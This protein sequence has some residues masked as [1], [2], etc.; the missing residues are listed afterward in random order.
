MAWIPI[1]G[2]LSQYQKSD[3]DL[4]SN[5]YIKFYASGTSTA[6]QMATDSSGSTLLDKCQLDSSGYPTTDG[7]SRFIPRIDQKY[8]IVL[9][10]N[11]ADANSNNTANADWIV[12]DV[13]TLA[14]DSQTVKESDFRLDRSYSTLSNAISSVGG[15]E[16]ELHLSE[17]SQNISSQLGISQAMSIRGK[18][19]Q[20]TGGSKFKV[21]I[22][23]IGM[24]VTAS[25]TVFSKFSIQPETGSGT[26]NDAI[27]L[28][29]VANV[30]IDRVEI[31]RESASSKFQ[32][33]L[34][35]FSAI[36]SNIIN[37][38]MTN[39]TNYNLRVR[40]D[41]GAAYPSNAVNDFGGYYAG[42]GVANIQVLDSDGFTKFGGVVEAPSGS[43]IGAE[44][45]NSDNTGFYGTWFENTT[46]NVE[47]TTSNYFKMFGGNVGDSGIEI[48][49][50]C[51]NNAFYSLNFPSIQ[52]DSGV[53]NTTFYSC[54]IPSSYTDNGTQTNYT[55]CNVAGVG[56][57][58]QWD[59]VL[60]AILEQKSG[61]TFRLWRSDFAKIELMRD[62]DGQN[63]YIIQDSV[64]D[65]VV[66]KVASG[67][68]T[69]ILRFDLST[70]AWRVL[71]M[72]TSSAGLTS[73][74][75]WNN[76]G[77]VNVA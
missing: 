62:R 31:L 65:L 69:E 70:G 15:N 17:G 20:T 28:N 39:A 4:A 61:N 46:N 47:I 40:N 26:T 49:T 23:V 77:V 16:S 57:K 11:A 42:A 13:D 53:T 25:R 3:G 12:D 51:N 63:G 34:N 32:N 60:D 36:S 55:L 38:I 19:A 54:G 41:S 35:M 48:K 71:N 18:G 72:P 74:S 2:T 50:G 37:C 59:K 73:G 10:K 68:S 56:L 43:G 76:S 24:L 67:V 14:L 8:K 29:E 75:L 27:R 45:T 30:L 33:G 9:F 44:I 58:S 6:I 7:S 66:L 5:Y 21:N 1:S 22:D 64:T 52:I